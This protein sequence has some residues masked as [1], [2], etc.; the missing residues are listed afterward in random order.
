M[1]ES[2][3]ITKNKNDHKHCFLDAKTGLWVG[4]AFDLHPGVVAPGNTGGYAEA[5]ASNDPVGA[6]GV[7][8]PCVLAYGFATRFLLGQA[9]Q[10]TSGF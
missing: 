4:T 9:L 6:V 8:A 3:Y 10:A 2:A 1:N 7:V 5:L